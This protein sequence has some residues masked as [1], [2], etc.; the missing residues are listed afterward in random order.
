MSDSENGV[1]EQK[2]TKAELLQEVLDTKI[3]SS[4]DQ[5]W[6]NLRIDQLE[7]LKNLASARPE[8][9]EK[10]EVEEVPLDEQLHVQIVARKRAEQ[11]LDSFKGKIKSLVETLT[12]ALK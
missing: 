2:P 1:N 9:E 11:E 8:Q 6:S 3:I 10:E 12:E 5:D 4:E 7:T